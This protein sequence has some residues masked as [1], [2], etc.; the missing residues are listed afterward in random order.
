[1]IQFKRNFMVNIC[2]EY[3]KC[4]NIIDTINSLLMWLAYEKIYLSIQIIN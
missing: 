1:M 2:E 3:N 4:L